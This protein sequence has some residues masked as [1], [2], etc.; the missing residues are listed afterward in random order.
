[1]QDSTG[2]NGPGFQIGSPL[3]EEV[4]APLQAQTAV[5]INLI[6]DT[7]SSQKGLVQTSPYVTLPNQPE[8]PRTTSIRG[9]GATG[10]VLLKMDSFFQASNQQINQLFSSSA[11]DPKATLYSNSVNEQVNHLSDSQ[12]TEIAAGKS[13]QE[14]KAM[15]FYAIDN[16]E[17]EALP[18][19][20]S[21]AEVIQKQAEETSG[22]SSDE[23][24]TQ[25]QNTIVN[26]SYDLALGLALD[27]SSLTDDEKLQ[28]TFAYR[29]PEFASELPSKLQSV[30][31]NAKISAFNAIK[32]DYSV[33]DNWTADSDTDSEDLTA[34]LNETFTQDVQDALSDKLINGEITKEQFQNLTRLLNNPEAQVPNKNEL[35]AMLETLQ[36]SAKS[37]LQKEWGFPDS[38][39]PQTSTKSFNDVTNG[40]FYS[41]LQDELGSI[42]PPL[43]Q[44]DLLLAQA[45]IG[46]QTALAS[47][48]DAVVAIIKTKSGDQTSSITSNDV[49][50]AFPE[51]MQKVDAASKNAL[52]SVKKAY[53]LPFDWIPS[54]DA[55]SKAA[56]LSQ[57]TQGNLELASTGIKQAQEWLANAEPLIDSMQAAGTISHD[58]VSAFKSYLMIVGLALNSLRDSV[59][60]IAVNEGKISSI[61]N[62]IKN[63]STLDKL[64]KKHK[65]IQDVMEKQKK[66]AALGPLQGMMRWIITIILLLVCP[67]VGIALLVNS[68]VQ[69]KGDVTKVDIFK[70]FSKSMQDVGKKIGGPGGK[71]FGML[72]VGLVV[73][74]APMSLILDLTF[75]KG[76]LVKTFLESAGID[77]KTAEKITQG[78]QMAAMVVTMAAA[79]ILAAP[80]GG[81][82]IEIVLPSFMSSIGKAALSAART[83]ASVLEPILSRLGQIGNYIKSFLNTIA[84]K[85]QVYLQE[86]DVVV[87]NLK[88]LG[89]KI[90]EQQQLVN[91]L[92]SETEGKTMFKATQEVSKKQAEIN[93][94]SK[95]LDELMSLTDEADLST[96]ST[97]L[98]SRVQ[99]A[100]TRNELRRASDAMEALQEELRQELEILRAQLKQNQKILEKL[101]NLETATADLKDMHAALKQSVER[102]KELTENFV[103]AAMIVANVSQAIPS[104]RN[105]IIQAQI[106]KIKADYDSWEKEAE[107]SISIM[108][109]IVDKLIGDLQ[110]MTSWIKDIGD[111]QQTILRAASRTAS[112]IA[113]A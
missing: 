72:G 24:R 59:Y 110:S 80:S 90:E 84:D 97:T 61:M 10:A 79:I 75:G 58:M 5:K 2:L 36:V 16:P 33:P 106:A 9:A 109:D 92:I 42:N 41:A 46:N 39:S 65:E 55:I 37:S 3:F 57:S 87:S 15:L 101:K 19:V 107:A 62:K 83:V 108:Q 22:V 102:T 100:A 47:L 99:E 69:N 70:D 60:E 29:M 104:M 96:A 113:M 54:P 43:S 6:F 105:S 49:K 53:S 45:S 21:L 40:A 1:M 28:V 32:A 30:L 26:T 34:Q 81:A 68:M 4:N 38:F 14:A 86:M 23:M 74:L 51:L 11:P 50:A 95:L 103:N 112:Q 31:E 8:L 91:E 20:K 64:A 71:A 27:A 111:Q 77:K 76:D 67:V 63:Q 85:L 13:P 93:K 48:P 94:N 18:A 56:N 88:K 73:G 35:N 98:Q 17:K 82:S 25:I 78:I 7:I 66:L 52:S 44:T 12:L 89:A